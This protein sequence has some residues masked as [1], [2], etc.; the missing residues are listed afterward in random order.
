VEHGVGGIAD[1]H[2]R[3]GVPLVLG[4]QVVGGA[5]VDL[6]PVELLDDGE[7]SLV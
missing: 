6:V 5:L 1:E 2:D 3:V 4:V 7:Q